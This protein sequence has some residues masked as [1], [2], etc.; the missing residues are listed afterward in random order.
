MANSSPP[1]PP[2]LDEEARGFWIQLQSKYTG[3]S[4]DAIGS[5]RW[6]SEW[7]MH[8]A[9]GL[10]TSLSFQIVSDAI[11][12]I[13][14]G[15][16]PLPT[17][18]GPYDVPWQPE[19]DADCQAF[20][21]ALRA[22]YR[23]EHPNKPQ[24]VDGLGYTR[25]GSDYRIARANGLNHERATNK[26]LGAIR[27]IWNIPLP[28]T[29]N[30]NRLSGVLKQVGWQSFDETGPKIYL[31]CHTMS[32][33]SDWFRPEKRERV[34]NSLRIIANKYGGIRY[35]DVLGYYD[36]NRDGESPW[37]AWLGKELTPV[38]F[39]S[40]S[41]RTISPTPDYWE[42]YR[43]LL[44]F[45]HELKLKV[46]CDRG[47]LNGLT[48]RQKITHMESVGRMFGSLGSI[49]PEVLGALFALNEP[50]QNG[51][52]DP[53]DVQLLKD[54]IW[55]FER[56]AGWLPSCVGL[57]DPG[58][59]GLESEDPASL[60]ALAPDPATCIVVHGNRGSHDHIIEHYRGYGYDQT[61]RD[62]NKKVWNREPVGGGPGVSVGQVNDPEVLCGVVL[63]A[64]TSGQQFTFMSGAGV[65][66]EGLVEE[67]PGFNEVARLTEWL[68]D[69]IAD[70]TIVIHSGDRFK[71]TRIMAAVDPTR[72][73]ASHHADGRFAA[74][75]HTV[76][77]SGNLL[78]CERACSEFTVINPVTGDVERS[79]PIKV[80]EK[81]KH[82]G[83]V[84]LVIGKLS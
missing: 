59:Q 54:M 15:G 66:G 81:F 56:G 33:L 37:T 46:M 72:F 12:A 58:G 64:L 31:F 3:G 11:D 67:M 68:P 50:W 49:G 24:D 27:R 47:D 9:N 65:F 55:A 29:E 23:D 7:R 60:I 30:R 83:K 74:V 36:K 73:D 21:D 71:G 61:I 82:E 40:H 51:G 42:G 35:C 62:H 63:G 1:W 76:E 69:D 48:T 18:P 6:P 53:I 5:V 17:P 10:S 44:L 25:W 32:F 43:E 79:G 19:M 8:R 84:R 26:V 16:Q 45:C 39:V 2:Q 20:I 52:G 34:K 70:F 80:G 77:T 78:P 28:V 22:A 14:S 57:G 38:Q 41:G 13:R 75:L 4:I